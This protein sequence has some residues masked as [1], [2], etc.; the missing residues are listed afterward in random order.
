MVG[1]TGIIEIESGTVDE[2][3]V[4]VVFENGTVL[5]KLRSSADIRN[6]A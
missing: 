4:C 1:S 3:E 2:L 6:M 5:A